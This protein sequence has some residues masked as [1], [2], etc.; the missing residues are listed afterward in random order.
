M[1]FFRQFRSIIL[2]LLLAELVF[3]SGCVRRRL[4][5]RTNPPGAVAYLDN[6]ELG[7]TP[8][9]RNFEYYGKR[10]LKLVREG[11]EPHVEMI[12]LRAPWYQWPGLDFVSEVLIPGTIT[13]ERV[14]PIN[15]KPQQIVS[16]DDLIA[17]GERLKAIA[18]SSGTYRVSSGRERAVLPQNDPFSALEF[19]AQPTDSGG[20]QF[21]VPPPYPLDPPLTSPS[22]Y[23]QP[24]NLDS[25]SFNTAPMPNYTPAPEPRI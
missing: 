22:T 17:E 14:Y 9:S 23:L 13:D 11:Y 25:Y 8:I 16:Q 1:V 6:V 18:H 15:L 7:K 5:V 4:T 3:V 24:G 19:E 10:E 20:E 21:L 12:H 2:L